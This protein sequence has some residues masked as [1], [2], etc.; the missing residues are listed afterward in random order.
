MS[1]FA[2]LSHRFE[3]G[4]QQWTC[5]ST[6]VQVK[7]SLQMFTTSPSTGDN[8]SIVSMW[9]IAEVGMMQQMCF[10]TSSMSLLKMWIHAGQSRFTPLL[11]GQKKYV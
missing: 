2:T 10:L 11:S 1:T 7:E 9:S 4:V 5:S 6:E 3:L 8:V